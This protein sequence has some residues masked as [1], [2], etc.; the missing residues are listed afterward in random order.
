MTR[1]LAIALLALGLAGWR[2]TKLPITSP[3][4]VYGGLT[5]DGGY[6]LTGGATANSTSFTITGV[7]DG[8]AGKLYVLAVTFDGD[9]VQPTPGTVADG[10]TGTWG[11]LKRMICGAADPTWCEAG[12]WT[13]TAT[14]NGT[15]ITVTKTG[16]TDNWA[17]RYALYRFSGAHATQNGATSGTGGTG[18]TSLQTTLTATYNGSMVLG[19]STDA[20]GVTTHR[21]PDTNNVEDTWGNQPFGASNLNAG[22]L[23]YNTTT[24]AS[25]S[26]TMGY[27]DTD[28][29]SV[30]A[31]VEIRAQ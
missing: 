11:S 31:A 13:S 8:T 28:T 4:V 2:D 5:L 29:F 7:G 16:A 22:I 23:R 9:T 6:P 10:L 14:L 20:G 27:N 17:W 24:T 19:I 3:V 21:T 1:R 15:T 30:T 18:S 25:G 26:Y 12:F